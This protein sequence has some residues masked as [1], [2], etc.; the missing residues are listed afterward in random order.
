MEK[1]K[2]QERGGESKPRKIIEK[3]VFDSP[4]AFQPICLNQ[5]WHFCPL[6]CI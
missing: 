1:P 2:Y 6:A 4:V 3:I 5:S